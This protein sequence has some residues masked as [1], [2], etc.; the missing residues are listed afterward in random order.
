MAVAALA[1]TVAAPAFAQDDAALDALIDGSATPAEALSLARKQASQGDTLGG[2]AT[3][4]RALMTHSKNSAEVRLYYATLLCRLGDRQT[5]LGEIA[6]TGHID[7]DSPAWAETR[8]ACGEVALPS[9][10]DGFSFGGEASVGFAYDSDLSRSLLIE[11]ALPGYPLV[12]SDDG[13]SYTQ[14]LRAGFRAPSGGAFFYGTMGAASRNPLQGTSPYFQTADASLGIG[15]QRGGLQF[16]LGA[17]VRHARIGG[18]PFVT[19][20]GGEAEIAV[21]DGPGGRLALRGELVRQDFMGSTPAFSRDGSRY[22]IG[23]SY[24]GSRGAT[25]YAL[26]G[27]YELKTADTART[28]YGGF[29]VGGSLRQGLTQSGA[30][31]SVTSTL[32]YVEYRNENGFTP[33]AETRF[34]SRAALGIPLGIEGLDVE[35]AGSYASRSYNATSTLRNYDNVGAELRLVWT[36]GN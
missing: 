3:L 6:S 27:A 14:S 17:V 29:R 31:A 19:E 7:A 33:V 1:M 9:D 28:G 32:R 21:L 5:A 13:V 2:A 10:D 24:S 15:T 22:D 8:A 18:H 36:F 30:Y 4:E 35:A 34:L 23:V 20:L 25:R 26:G 12:A 16:S 11:Y